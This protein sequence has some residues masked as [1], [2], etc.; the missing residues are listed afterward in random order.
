[1]SYEGG[2]HNIGDQFDAIEKN[3]YLNKILF[4]LI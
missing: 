2:V 4:C 1:M 3:V